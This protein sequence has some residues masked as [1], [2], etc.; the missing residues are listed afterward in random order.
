MAGVLDRFR[1]KQLAQ[2]DASSHSSKDAT[3]SKDA[4]SKGD[5]SKA[6]KSRNDQK[7]KDSKG[8]EQ[9]PLVAIGSKHALTDGERKCILSTL[10]APH[11]TEKALNLAATE[12]TY[13]FDVARNATKPAVARAVTALYDVQVEDV[14]MIRNKARGRLFRG[15]AGTAKASKKAI[16]RVKDGDRIEL[17]EQSV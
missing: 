17:F 3:S 12:N 16:V 11:M 8:K 2:S 6:R 13:V 14:R 9:R 1:K 4:S 5:Q 7:E 10:S 15:I